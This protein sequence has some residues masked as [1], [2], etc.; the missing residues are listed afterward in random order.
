MI[1]RLS[2]GPV[3]A[4]ALAISLPLLVPTFI[5]HSVALVRRVVEAPR[6]S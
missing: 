5:L 4:V 1:V 2:G 6:S 3:N